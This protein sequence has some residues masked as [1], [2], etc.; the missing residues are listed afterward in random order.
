MNAFL[1]QFNIFGKKTNISDNDSSEDEWLKNYLKNRPLQLTEYIGQENVKNQAAMKIALAKKNNNAFCHTLL[2]GNA[3]A[4]KTTLAKTIAN[5]M[6][7]SF[8]EYLGSNLNNIFELI[9]I[10]E[11]ILPNSILFI[12]EIHMMHKH[13]Q[14]FLYPVLE[15]GKYLTPKSPD[16]V[17][18]NNFTIIGC[19]THAGMLNHPFLERF[20]WKPTLAPYSKSEMSELIK[21]TA[22][23]K[24][25][26][27]LN[28]DVAYSLANLSQG[29]PRKAVHLIQNF[30]DIA[31][32]HISE[33]RDVTAEDLTLDNLTKTCQSLDMDPVIGLD[34]PFRDY[35]N[36]LQNENG[37]PVGVRTLAAMCNQQEVTLLNQLEPVLMQ[38]NIEIP[39]NDDNIITGPLVKVTRGGRVATPSTLAYLKACKNLQTN[40]DWF[41]GEAFVTN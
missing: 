16:G 24:F 10:L 37:K 9:E 12:D 14:E 4:G 21:K 36:I 1:K 33:V 35:L 6:Q 31:S 29:T 27:D 11:N 38:N 13:I 40:H 3:G 15:D 30:I 8:Y 34:R 28:D 26:L 19:T 22:K 32:C 39:I 5:E 18:L 20:T 25:N 7:S 17:K 41:K 2:L 23:R